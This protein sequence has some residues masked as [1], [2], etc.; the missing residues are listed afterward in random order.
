MT[1]SLLDFWRSKEIHRQFPYSTFEGTIGNLLSA[2]PFYVT[3]FRNNTTRGP[4]TKP[5][6]ERQY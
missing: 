5:D 3:M 6:S 2:H 1:I 4:A